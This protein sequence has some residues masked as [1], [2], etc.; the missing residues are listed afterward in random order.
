MTLITQSQDN[1]DTT[2]ALS[3]LAQGVGFTCSGLLAWLGG[4]CMQWEHRD[5][6]MGII[7]SVFAP[8]GLYCGLR[9]T[10]FH[11]ARKTQSTSL[12]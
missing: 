10:K 1:E 8:A 4:L 2:I 5:L 11:P 9:S 3:G 7:Y 6:W 12:H